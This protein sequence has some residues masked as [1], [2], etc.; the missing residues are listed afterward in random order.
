MEVYKYAYPT[1]L[2]G[3]L[4]VV[5]GTGNVEWTIVVFLNYPDYKIHSIEKCHYAVYLPYR[6]ETSKIMCYSHT[7]S[8]LEAI[9]ILKIVVNQRDSVYVGDHLRT[10]IGKRLQELLEEEAQDRFVKRFAKN[11]YKCWYDACSN[12]YNPIG[13]KRILRDFEDLVVDII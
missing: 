3:I 2:D 13:R 12:P 9:K 11:I 1:A 7:I 10:I 6:V 8:R 4:K 5:S